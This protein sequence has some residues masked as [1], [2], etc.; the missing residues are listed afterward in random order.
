MSHYAI[1]AKMKPEATMRQMRAI[2]RACDRLN[3]GLDA[4]VLRD[5]GTMYLPYFKGNGEELAADL[6]KLEGVDSVTLTH[7][8]ETACGVW[9]KGKR[10]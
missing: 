8:A 1:S 2:I 4:S 6:S 10:S 3:A 7:I 9:R 5:E